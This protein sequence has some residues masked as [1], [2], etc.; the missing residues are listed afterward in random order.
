MLY[1][2]IYPS[3]VSLI[4]YGINT[5]V[6]TLSTT[7]P[8]LSIDLQPLP[9]TNTPSNT[10]V[11][12]ASISGNAMNQ[13]FRAPCI[14]VALPW[15]SID[16]QYLKPTTARPHD[17]FIL[18][19]SIIGS[20]RLFPSP[21]PRS[22]P[23]PPFSLLIQNSNKRRRSSIDDG[24][25]RTGEI[26]PTCHLPPPAVEIVRNIPHSRQQALES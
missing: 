22:R 16:I 11:I 5:F 3:K 9:R 20:C 13:H 12:F 26:I 23:A 1:Y 17:I 21:P 24:R 14:V 10:I 2:I 7:N 4:S 19:V 18:V 15:I 6:N 8:N 25:S